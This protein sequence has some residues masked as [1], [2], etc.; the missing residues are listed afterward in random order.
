[1]GFGSGFGVNFT[2][3]T[4]FSG[5]GGGGGIIAPSIQSGLTFL[6]A[7]TVLSINLVNNDTN[8]PAA[9]DL[10][11]SDS[12]LKAPLDSFDNGTTTSPSYVL[13][14]GETRAITLERDIGT[15]GYGDT[16]ASCTISALLADGSTSTTSVTVEGA[17]PVTDYAN[18]EAVRSGADFSLSSS[19]VTFSY[20]TNIGKWFDND[21][22]AATSG[23]PGGGAITGA[24]NSGGYIVI[25]LGQEKFVN[26]IRIWVDAPSGNAWNGTNTV[27]TTVYGDTASDFS[28]QTTLANNVEIYDGGNITT[29]DGS[30]A[31]DIKVNQNGN[32]WRREYTLT[33]GVYRYL[34]LEYQSGAG[35]G[36]WYTSE[37]QFKVN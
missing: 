21:F 27:R 31:D 18:W 1:M 16:P 20:G 11:F 33:G 26:E 3:S 29:A 24:W 30:V 5:G 35:H 4:R 34:K 22:T 15:P 13:E 19:G 14:P 8:N 25:D 23:N 37:I 28:G 9:L 6:E 32:K 17:T 10:S 2:A 36:Y 12:I 7:D